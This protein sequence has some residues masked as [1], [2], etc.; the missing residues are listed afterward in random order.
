M[1]DQE[2]GSGQA[3]VCGEL[4]GAEPL[5]RVMCCAASQTDLALFQL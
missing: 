1:S 3:E 2:P 5:T 4:L